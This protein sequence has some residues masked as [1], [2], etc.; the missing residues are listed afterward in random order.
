MRV[1]NLVLLSVLL[2]ACRGVLACSCAAPM[3]DTETTVRHAVASADIVF[4]GKAERVLTS[5][6]PDE[7]YG[8]VIQE[9]TFY[10]LESWKGEKATRVSTRINVQCCVCGYRFKEGETYLVFGYEGQDNYYRASTCSLT[11]HVDSADEYLAILGELKA[12]E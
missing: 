12:E 6:T 3:D 5:H 8:A 1:S 7:E 2:F 4:L 9:S 11:M 10:I